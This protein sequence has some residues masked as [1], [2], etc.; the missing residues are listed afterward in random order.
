MN[1]NSTADNLQLLD[2]APVRGVDWSGELRVQSSGSSLTPVVQLKDG[3][4]FPVS[5]RNLTRE[6][7][8]FY[9][10]AELSE[11]IE[12]GNI[13]DTEQAVPVITEDLV[14]GKRSVATGSVQIRKLV[15]EHA[16][17][18][19]LPLLRDQVDVRRVIIDR[20]VDTEPRTREEGDVLIVPVVK[21]ELVVTK[22]LILKEELHITRRRTIEHVSEQVAVRSERAEVTRLDADGNPAAS[23]VTESSLE[24]E[25][26]SQEQP[27]RLRR[28]SILE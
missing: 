16:E 20:V 14:V 19:E 4:T 22:R 18:V 10:S 27:R 23:K 7:D 6:S 9:L 26:V 1:Q 5:L 25:P 28:K 24:A 12:A 2:H 3:R 11:L 13:P 15:D 8:G 21:E 17:T